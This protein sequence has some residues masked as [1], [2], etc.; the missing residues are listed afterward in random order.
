MR[1][2]RAAGAA[3][4]LFTLASCAKESAP[5]ETEYVLFEGLPILGDN[6]VYAN[7]SGNGYGT[8][9]AEYHLPTRTLT[10]DI[11]YTLLEGDSASQAHFH[12]PATEHTEGPL[13]INL[14][15]AQMT[16]CGG[17]SGTRTMDATQEEL[18]LNGRYYLN[19]HSVQYPQGA[20]R[21]Q[22]TPTGYR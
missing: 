21:T 15:M 20:L 9:N 17:L 2:L 14:L 8:V 18:L 3:F 11:A 12:G 4:I 10:Y 22:M 5:G 13:D 19:L 6:Q 7:I 1:I 16:T